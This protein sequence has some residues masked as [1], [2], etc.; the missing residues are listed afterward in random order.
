M[1]AATILFSLLLICLNGGFVALE[2][3]LIG[4]QRSRIDAQAAQGSRSARK[5]QRMQS[6][7]LTTLGGA[8][9]GITLCSLAVGR[10]AEPAVSELIE[11]AL[12]GIADLPT[13][14]LHTLGFAVS[15]TLVAVVHMVLG[16]M[17]PKNLA[18]IGPERTLL[19]LA[20][21]MA[22]YLTVARP[23]VRSLLWLANVGLS[24]VKVKP[25][26]ELNES[27]TPAQFAVMVSESVSSDLVDDQALLNVNAALR[28]GTTLAGDVMTPIRH[29]P[30]VQLGQSLADVG[31]QFIAAD[32]TRLPVYGN[33]RSDV[34]GFVHCTDLVATAS[35]NAGGPDA[36]EPDTGGPDTGGP[37]A[38]GPDAGGPDAE[39]GAKPEYDFSQVKLG[40]QH[41]RDLIQVGVDATLP[42]VVA[43]MR[44][45]RVNLLLVASGGVSQGVIRLDDLMKQLTTSQQTP[46]Q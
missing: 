28:F 40:T 18:L 2:F 46:E 13:G 36:G 9:L 45:H 3:G 44:A 22:S 42:Q 35:A 32:T 20:R 6:D 29:A 23:V 37:D 8:Q 7:V 15:L 10:L 1:T 31:R 27:V 30:A 11:S 16:E 33:D 19:V 12:D 5:A 25:K 41:L 43:V 26:N 21:P 4:G 14:V 39:P 38:G 34:R 17:V 24:L